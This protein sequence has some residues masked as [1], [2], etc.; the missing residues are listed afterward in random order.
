V[1]SGFQ[2]MT[3]RQPLVVNFTFCGDDR[4]ARSGRRGL[5]GCASCDVLYT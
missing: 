4:V 5:P 2:N 3:M 1:G